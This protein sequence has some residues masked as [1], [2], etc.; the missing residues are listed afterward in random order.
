MADDFAHRYGPW[1]LVTG[2]SSGIGE[3]FA[4][5]LAARGLH[6]VISARRTALLENLAT[7]IQ[8]QHGTQ[9]EVLAVDLSRPDFIEPLMKVCEGKEI[10]LVVSN[11]G[12]GLKGEHHQLDA[13]RLS[14]MLNV[15]CRAP[16]LIAHAFAPGLIARGRGGLLLTGSIEGFIGFPLST[17][18]AATKAFVMALGEGLW[19]ELTARG[20]D[21]M[22]L[23]PGATDTDAPTLQGID[24][25]Q[26]V[27]LMPPSEV[28]RQALAQLGR[29]P[30][31]I[32]GWMNRLM[33]K[34]LSALPRRVA[35]RV[36]GGAMKTALERSRKVA[37]RAPR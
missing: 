29:K 18:Y 24:R 23:A 31:F 1:A 15:N 8:R 17:A 12:F 14:A 26:L 20:V 19:G 21:V 32:T 4:R 6:L 37:S 27:G 25:S 16:M 30:V 3:Q 10:G 34:F 28:V 2:A 9:V 22:V 7:D 5:Q 11:A 35:V 33:V 36:A 13:A